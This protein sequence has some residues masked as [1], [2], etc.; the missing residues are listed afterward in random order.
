MLRSAGER[1]EPILAEVDGDGAGRVGRGGDLPPDGTRRRRRLGGKSRRVGRPECFF[2]REREGAAGG[3][4]GPKQADWTVAGEEDPD[5]ESPHARRGLADRLAGPLR[6]EAT[7]RKEAD[8]GPS[9]GPSGAGTNPA[10]ANSGSAGDGLRDRNSSDHAQLP[11]PFGSV[12]R[13]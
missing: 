3:E 9:L 4:S 12:P 8:G 5:L 2:P 1:E 7:D 13:G 10:E 11:S 6:A